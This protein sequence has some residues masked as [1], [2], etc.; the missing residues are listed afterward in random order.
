MTWNVKGQT[1]ET[2]PAG[3]TGPQGEPGAAAAKGDPGPAGPQGPQGPSGP[4]GSGTDVVYIDR[5]V[6]LPADPSGNTSD[7]SQFIDVPCSGGTKVVN[8]AAI[9]RA[10]IAGGESF[11]N[12]DTNSWHFEYSSNRFN[13]ESVTYTFRAICVRTG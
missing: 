6:T 3:P 2:G 7:A 12:T 11:P 5:V 10:R 4:P 1:G 9:P 8:G 13:S